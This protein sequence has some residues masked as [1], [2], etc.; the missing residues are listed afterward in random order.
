M[1]IFWVFRADTWWCFCWTWHAVA[2][3]EVKG[4]F[5]FCIRA[6]CT[7]GSMSGASAEHGCV[8]SLRL[9]SSC[10]GARRVTWS[11]ST[12]P[13]QFAFI[14]VAGVVYVESSC[15]RRCWWVMLSRWWC[16]IWPWLQC[17]RWR[18]C[19]SLSLNEHP[20]GVKGTSGQDVGVPTEHS[21]GLTLLTLLRYGV[22]V[23][24]ECSVSMRS[25]PTGQASNAVVPPLSSLYCRRCRGW[26]V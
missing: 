18:C 11:L 19:C 24:G 7:E 2:D 3:D 15:A 16:L 12:E 9:L 13:G 23:A 4:R 25:V 14:D 1:I 22:D 6:T 17:L 8:E 20:E 21:Y 26:C 10:H 5:W